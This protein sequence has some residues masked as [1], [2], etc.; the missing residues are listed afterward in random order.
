M[1]RRAKADANQQQIVRELRALGMSVRHTHTIGQG[2]PDLAV[3][4][5]GVTLLVELKVD[6]GRLSADEVEFFEAWRGA[7]IVART[8]EEIVR[9]FEAVNTPLTK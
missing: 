8:S 1:R 5:R 9:W 4:W 7:A 2:F 6:G 3:G